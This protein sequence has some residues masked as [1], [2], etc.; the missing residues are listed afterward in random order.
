[1]FH[2][3]AI[4]TDT[5]LNP[6]FSLFGGRPDEYVEDVTVMAAMPPVVTPEPMRDRRTV[7]RKLYDERIGQKFNMLTIL[8]ADGRRMFC[9]CDCGKTHHVRLDNLKSGM[10]RSCGCVSRSRP[11]ASR[12]QRLEKAG[13]QRLAYAELVAAGS[14]RIV[15]TTCAADRTLPMFAG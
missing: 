5:K 1:M 15:A 4:E 10:T 13:Q 6:A 11:G 3:R 14:V 12:R 7:A 2:P 9:Q 8:R